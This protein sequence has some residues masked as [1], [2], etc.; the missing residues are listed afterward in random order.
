MFVVVVFVVVGDGEDDG[1][2]GVF[3]VVDEVF[4]IVDYEGVVVVYC[5]GF[6]WIGVGV[7]VWFGEG[8]VIGFFVLYVG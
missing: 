7:G 2:V 3:G 1:E 4:V 8:E 5:V 6:D